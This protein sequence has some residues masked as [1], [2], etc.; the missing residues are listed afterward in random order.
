MENGKTGGGGA[1]EEYEDDNFTTTDA[2]LAYFT[3]VSVS[4]LALEWEFGPFELPAKGQGPSA[5]LALNSALTVAMVH[6]TQ[7]RVQ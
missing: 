2:G 1:G 4:N 3:R 6:H 5:T 7:I